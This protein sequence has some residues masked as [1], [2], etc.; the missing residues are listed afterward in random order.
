M[1]FDGV[2]VSESNLASIL[3]DAAHGT[4]SVQDVEASQNPTSW[5]LALVRAA[6]ASS[7]RPALGRAVAT[8]FESS[9]DSE[10]SLALEAQRQE[11][12][13]DGS[14]LWEIL[15]EHAGAQRF[16]QAGRVALALVGLAGRGS[17]LYDDRLRD[18]LLRSDTPRELADKLLTLAGAHDRDWLVQHTELV[19]AG[20][21]DDT[22]MRIGEV[23]AA[24][25][26]SALQ[27]FA[28]KLAAAC[29]AQGHPLP[30]STLD[31][32]A[33][34]VDARRQAGR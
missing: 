21:D 6:A 2:Q 22:L 12:V 3:R 5:A 11:P 13:V 1:D 29:A 15:F 4:V 20:S 7:L 24:L 32:L 30:K 17:Q 27:D 34:M 26:S 25:G 9:D 31:T 23:A 33:E 14:L 18:L 8:L 16:E 10:V 19:L 28:A